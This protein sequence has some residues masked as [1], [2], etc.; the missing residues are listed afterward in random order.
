MELFFMIVGGVVLGIAALAIN[1]SHP[2]IA[3]L[4]AAFGVGILAAGLVV[5]GS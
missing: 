2:K 4:L 3:L 1:G 5:I